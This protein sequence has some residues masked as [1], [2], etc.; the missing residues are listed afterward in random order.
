[1][2][3]AIKAQLTGNK[4]DIDIPA[5]NYTYEEIYDF[6]F[7]VVLNSDY[8]EFDGNK[9]TKLDSN[10]NTFKKRLDNAMEL[11]IVGIVRPTDETMSMANIG[12]IGYL[13][14]LKEEII[15][16]SNNSDVVKAQLKNPDIDMFTG[17]RFDSK[18]YTIES[19]PLLKETIEK[20][21]KIPGMNTEYIL[22]AVLD[23]LGMPYLKDV[24]TQYVP[25]SPESLAEIIINHLN[26]NRVTENTYEDNL[27]ALGYI[28]IE[29]PSSISIYPKDFESKERINELI[30]EYNS[31]QNEDDKI[32]YSDTV[33]LL[34]SSVTTIIDA[35]SYVLIAFVAISLIV[36]SI[37]I[38]VITYISVLER[39]K[40]I[41][42]LRAIGASKKD[43]AR[44][45]NAE[46]LFVGFV[47]GMIGIICSLGLI[48]IINIILYHFT[49]IA[50]LQAILEPKPA[51]ILVVISMGLTFIAGL[52]PSKTASKKDPV[53]ALRTE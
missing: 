29:N 11:K 17:I 18:G 45:F 25:T 43:I 46:T 14:S 33:A 20:L 26:E 24:I 6:D 12:T 42:I 21:Q 44:V 10:S 7:K 16:K 19:F 41:G 52:F 50:N 3:A 23:T 48:V 13:S 9:I 40:E 5:T 4:V 37:M 1:M 28:D 49:G 22:D 53:I 38:G 39:T 30:A 36:S 34:M 35:I 27:V 51:I 31:K 15:E 8:Y 47:A 32:I 2:E